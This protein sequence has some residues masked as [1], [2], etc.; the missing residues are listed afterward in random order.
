MNVMDWF[1]PNHASFTV[2]YL[3]FNF[4]EI[5]GGVK[6][7][8]NCYWFIYLFIVIFIDLFRKCSEQKNLEIEDHFEGERK[9]LNIKLD[10]L[11]SIL[12]MFE[13][14]AKNSQVKNISMILK[15]QNKLDIT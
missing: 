10:S 12:K 11:S 3:I 7:N 5:G 9:E 8:H 14:K 6:Q 13:L 1:M 2:M 4:S 15:N